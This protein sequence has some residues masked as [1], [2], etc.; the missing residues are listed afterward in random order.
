MNRVANGDTAA[1]SSLYDVT[2][3]GVF[4]LLRNPA[5]SE[6]VLC[7]GCHLADLIQQA[8]RRT[9]ELR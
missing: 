2:A 4:G 6:E 7:S 9:D 1:F 3:P 5:Q 8:C